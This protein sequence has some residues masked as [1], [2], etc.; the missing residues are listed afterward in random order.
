MES[1]YKDKKFALDQKERELQLR[2]DEL[3]MKSKDLEHKQF[4]LLNADDSSSSSELAEIAERY[5][6]NSTHLFILQ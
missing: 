1:D 6:M 4:D 2:A 3:H 5:V